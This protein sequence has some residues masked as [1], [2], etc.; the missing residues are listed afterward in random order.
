MGGQSINLV[1]F[2]LWPLLISWW[3]RFHQGTSNSYLS[4]FQQVLPSSQ[5]TLSADSVGYST[6]VQGQGHYGKVKGQIIMLRKC[7]PW[8]ISLLI[9]T[10]YTI[11]FSRSGLDKI[12]QGQGHYGKVKGQIKLKLW[13]C[14]THPAEHHVWNQYPKAF[15]GWGVKT[16]PVAFSELQHKY[17]NIT[18]R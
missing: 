15:S 9:Y 11:P 14:T 4:T 16:I 13:C 6:L 17:I 12:F 18:S 7:T 2:H 8:L 3:L 1:R 5:N 10:S